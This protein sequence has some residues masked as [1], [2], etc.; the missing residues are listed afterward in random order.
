MTTNTTLQIA[1][2]AIELQPGE[3]YAG[4]VL[5]AAGQVKHH[6]ILLPARPDKRAPWQAQVDWA[7]S[8]GGT[9]PDRQEQALLYANCKDALP[10]VWC[11]SSETHEDSASY[12]WCCHF[13]VG[14]QYY[15]IKR[16]EGSAVAVR[17]I[18]ISS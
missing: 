11:W 1:P 7:A 13:Y 17:L 4:A 10:P 12:A 6:L 3:R 2:V 16:F 9:L 8:A 18:P 5:N 15:D 14:S